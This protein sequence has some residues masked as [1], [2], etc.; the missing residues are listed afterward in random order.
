MDE[1]RVVKCAS[2]RGEVV[3]RTPLIYAE[4]KNLGL[5]GSVQGLDQL[6][7]HGFRLSGRHQERI[8]QEIG[9]M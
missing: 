8:L 7:S 6:R 2:S 9:E 1:K 5:I 4:A 3:V